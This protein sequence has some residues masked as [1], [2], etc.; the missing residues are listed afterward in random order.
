VDREFG[1]E[2]MSRVCVRGGTTC[3][4]LYSIFSSFVVVSYINMCVCVSVSV[5]ALLV[6]YIVVLF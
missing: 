5:G 6:T 2:K 3:G 1:F 4:M